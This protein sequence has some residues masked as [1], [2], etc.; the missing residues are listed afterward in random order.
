VLFHSDP[1][2]VRA[3]CAA[4][5]RQTLR[6]RRVRVHLNEARDEEVAALT[7][8][9]PTS[10]AWTVT[11]STDN[12]GY[13]RAHND[14]LRASTGDA[15][16]AVLVLNPDVVLAPDAL[17]LLVKAAEEYGAPCL[18]GPLLELGGARMEPTG[19]IDSAGIRWTRSGRHL[20]ALQGQ[21]LA[22]APRATVAVSGMTG[23][24]ILVPR[25][26][27]A[28]IT[29]VGGEFFDEHFVAYREDAELGLRCTRLGIRCLL[30]PA[31][32]ARHARRLRGTSRGLSPAIN[33]LGVQNRML[34]RFKHGRS[35]PGTWPLPTL[36]DLVVVLAVLTR[37]RSSFPGVVS[38][39]RLRG[40][41]RSKGRLLTRA[42]RA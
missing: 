38:A 26:A 6:P 10:L 39:V 13:C 21:P 42:T 8:E 20:D 22:K 16:D 19:L 31:A 23:A 4:L 5:T 27:Y 3:T 15:A 30:V 2:Q 12:R 25:D 24:C 35:R 9:L 41:M 40:V 37:E 28:V 11:A 14:Q 32:T 7:A 29:A 18:L 36:R 17:E 1:A 33:R 34:I